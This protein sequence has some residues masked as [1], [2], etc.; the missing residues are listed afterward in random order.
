MSKQAKIKID[1]SKHALLPKHAK[2]SEKEKEE[3]LKKYNSTEKEFPK[4]LLNDS[5]I[6]HLD[7]KP[8]DIIK[9]SRKSLTSGEH[10]FYRVV[11]NE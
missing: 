11:S 3:L 2:A 5:G 8:G 1:I 10:T 9:I 7:V 6:M 4:I